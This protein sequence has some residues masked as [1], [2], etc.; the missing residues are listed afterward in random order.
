[1]PKIS[2]AKQAWADKVDREKEYDL[3]EAVKVLK[4]C[5]KAKFDESVEIAL[6][7]GLD[8][9]HADQ[10]VRGVTALP[11]GTGKTYRVAVIAK[12]DAAEAAKK[13][14]ADVVGDEDLVKKM[15]GGFLDFDR[16]VATPDCMPLVGRLGKIL[17]P[18][19][20]MPNPKLGTVTPNPAKAVE[21]IKAGQ[22][23][24]KLEKRGIVHAAVGKTSF[25]E[26]QIEE[27][28]QAFIDAIRAAKPS[29]AKGVYM[30]AM[31]ISSTMGPGVKVALSS[32][33][34]TQ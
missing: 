23:E 34:G 17:G 7:L 26:K 3:T 28:I 24:F 11:N 30:Q 8:P 14:G 21:D 19:G 18:K 10:Q 25:K 2:K 12:G 1:M 31:A 5:A 20:L 32:V 22:I 13:A 29:G 9:K 27:N 16:V 6:N 33:G 15:E 4:S